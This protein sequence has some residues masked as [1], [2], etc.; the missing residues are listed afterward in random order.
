MVRG[1]QNHFRHTLK[2]LSG[3]VRSRPDRE[4]TPCPKTGR[5]LWVL[6]DQEVTEQEVTAHRQA[7]ERAARER[8]DK[9]WQSHEAEQLRQHHTGL[10]K[11]LCVT[12]PL[13]PKKK[14][15]EQA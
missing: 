15:A 13:K 9:L 8:S 10:D 6:N 7:R 1:R 5:K 2:K 14:P 4:N 11:P 12:G 3:A